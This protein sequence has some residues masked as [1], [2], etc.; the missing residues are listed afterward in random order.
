MSFNAG[1]LVASIRLDGVD[2][3]L[4]DNQRAGDAFQRTGAAGSAAGRAAKAAM[5][6]A[7]L[8]AA[9]V[10]TAGIALLSTL[11]RTGAAYNTLQQTSRAALTTLLGGAQAA[12]DQM[13]K[14]DE[15]ARKSPFSKAVFI[16]A[17]QQLLGFGVEA[18][19]VIPILGAV[20]DAVAATGGSSAEIAGIVEVLAQIKS[21]GKIT[22]EE[23]MQL[24]GRGIDAAGMIGAS[25][26]KSGAEIKKSISEGALD[27]DTAIAA[28][29]AGMNS[30]FSGAAANVKNTW[31][32]ATDRIKAANR[33]I[34][35]ALAEPFISQ[36][37][38]GLAIT[39]GNQV[40]DV[41]RAILGQVGPV[42]SIL[43]ARALPTF[44]A[45]TTALDKARV[46]IK[47]WDPSQVER[48]LRAADEHGPAVAALAGALVGLTN[49]AL[50]PML[51]PLGALVPNFGLLGGTIG[52]LL[53]T[54][55]DGRR[56]LMALLHAFEPLIP[57]AE[58]L[59][60]ILASG[61]GM[62]MPLVAD[63][64]EALGRVLTPVM[65]TIA[66]LPT[67]V[68][69]GVAALLAMRGAI[70]P[71][72]PA[73]S[74]LVQS[75]MSMVTAFR[76]IGEQM[77]VQKALGAMEGNVGTLAGAFGFAGKAA[78]GLGGALKA[79]FI[80]NPVGLIL[81]AVTIAVV[82]LTAAFTAQAEAAE[83]NN[84]RVATYKDTLNQTTGAITE[85]TRAQVQKSLEDKKARE[86]ANG[87]HL[88]FNTLTDAA[89][90]NKEAMAK[91]TEAVDK[92]GWTTNQ[93]AVSTRAHKQSALDLLSV[94]GDERN[95]LK[96][97][98]DE[99][100]RNAEEHRRAI[101]A[102]SDAERSNARLAEAI[103]IA[104]D[105]SA[106]ATT[107][108]SALKQALD[109]LNGGTKSQAELTRD[110]NEQADRLREVW[111]A[112][113][114]NGNKLA[115]T[116]VNQAGVIDTTTA[117]GRALFD[118]TSRLND[119][120]MDAVLAEDKA[121]KARGEHGVSMERAAEVAKPYIEQLKTI[122]HEAGLSDEQV[123]GLVQTM[124]SSPAVISF[125][126]TDNGTTEQ[127]RAEM[128]TLAQQIIATP[129]KQ[130]TVK[131]DDFPGLAQAL[132]ALGVDIRSIPMGHVRV[133]KDDG[134]FASA[135][136]AL[137]WIAR[138]RTTWITV[139]TTGDIIDTSGHGRQV[140]GYAKGGPVIGPGTGTSDTAGLFALSN[141]EHVITA[142]E[143]AAA[144]GH[145]AVKAWRRSLLEGVPALAVGGPVG[146]F[147][148]TP[149]ASFGVP[150]VSMPPLVVPAPQQAS[151]AAVV[152]VGGTA[153]LTQVVELLQKIAAGPAASEVR[154][155]IGDEEI[156]KRVRVVVR[157]EQEK[158]A[159]SARRGN[160]R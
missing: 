26:G 101:A 134:S 93:G 148:A 59:A 79:A 56:A 89:M 66:S 87:L 83:E 96:Q 120:L 12:N 116:L 160:G 27:A 137:N 82:G 114:E 125:L 54:T 39:W 152:G 131:S 40:A 143:V 71:L 147:T 18:K 11:G 121:A 63:S 106:D 75:A 8:G 123:A 109:E 23:L 127:K 17:Q 69:A 5:D 58:D 155:F 154:V 141:G 21:Q 86:L 32:G 62:A 16:Q 149:A 99:T 119:K 30:K 77:A 126:V 124:L 91:V 6:Q 110:L 48:F 144:G 14:L 55:D 108:L 133:Q 102:M 145:E 94:L 2:T 9:A 72:T 157:D 136:A 34:G 105:V 68:L 111:L 73:V 57:V 4:R 142:R 139:R 70:G 90:G 97:A 84:K 38:G 49:N 53:L 15:F 51:G 103:R 129:D 156:T 46:V 92:Y 31:S 13:A 64:A 128:I 61:L 1:E 7:V 158:V 130:F 60:G 10:G 22:G 41:L 76:N 29:V 132:A 98:S 151:S 100:R 3:F 153:E 20:Q 107:R 80:T 65:Q 67:P 36:Q 43:E 85:A 104:S 28:L 45:I 47:S 118:E 122:A 35:A 37:G 42:V 113:D 78:T 50:R 88:D 146:D 19:N 159:R 140:S 135:D 150:V 74:A 81:T 112:A 115:T 24:G 25:L 138:D 33:E 44:A 95:S 117:A 52:A